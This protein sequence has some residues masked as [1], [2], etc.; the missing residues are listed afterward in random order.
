MIIIVFVVD[1]FFTSHVRITSVAN[2]K[3]ST[4]TQSNTFK[5]VRARCNRCN[6]NNNTDK[7]SSS[8]HRLGLQVKT[9]ED[10]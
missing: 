4:Q 8:D 10:I 2:D 3:I 7:T 1:T 9:D 6:N 5:H